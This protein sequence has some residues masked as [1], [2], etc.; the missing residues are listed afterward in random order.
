MHLLVPITQIKSIFIFFFTSQD[1]RKYMCNGINILCVLGH[2]FER[3]ETN[4]QS[5]LRNI[6]EEGRSNFCPIKRSVIYNGDACRN[7]SSHQVERSRKLSEID[8]Y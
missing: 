3:S 2:S 1:L 5:T 7:A 4:Y 8:R 6:E